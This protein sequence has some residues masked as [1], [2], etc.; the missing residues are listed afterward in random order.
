MGQTIRLGMKD[1]PEITRATQ[2]VRLISL[3]EGDTI[4]DIARVAPEDEEMKNGENKN[5]DE[6]LLTETES[7]PW[8]SQ[9]KPF[10]SIRLKTSGDPS[11]GKLLKLM[12]TQLRK[13][14]KRYLKEPPAKF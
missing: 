4:A 5:D 12:V 3:K 7:N 11:G 1:I 9:K 6:P 14:K 13:F 8:I 10:H 2:G